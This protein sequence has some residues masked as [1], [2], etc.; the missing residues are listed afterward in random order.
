MLFAGLSVSGCYS[1]VTCSS[2]PKTFFIFSFFTIFFLR[3]FH[4]YSMRIYFQHLK[5]M[6]SSYFSPLDAD[7]FCYPHLCVAV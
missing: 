6:I 5:V 2:Q 1:S 3:E 7:Q 4:V